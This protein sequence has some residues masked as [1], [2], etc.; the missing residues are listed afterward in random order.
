MAFI[1]GEEA[2][3]SLDILASGSSDS[4]HYASLGKGVTER[5]HLLVG[6]GEVWRIGNF[7]ETDEVDTTLDAIE[8]TT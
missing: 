3:G 4:G 1:S 5:Y 7:V 8:E 2:A 6:R